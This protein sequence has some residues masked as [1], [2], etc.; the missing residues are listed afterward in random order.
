[1]IE[2][3]R[4]DFIQISKNYEKKTGYNYWKE[5]VKYVVEFALELAR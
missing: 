4:N 2:K 1:M 5:H 3:I